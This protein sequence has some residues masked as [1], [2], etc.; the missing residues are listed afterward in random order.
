MG[1]TRYR[2]DARGR[3]EP[4]FRSLL[5]RN[6]LEFHVVLVLPHDRVPGYDPTRAKL[7]FEDPASHVVSDL[8]TFT[9]WS[10]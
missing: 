6:V 2:L 9:R 1:D 5:T 10:G 4:L 8:A 7:G 3:D